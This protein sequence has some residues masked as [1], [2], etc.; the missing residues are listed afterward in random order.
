MKAYADTGFLVKLY[1][2][3]PGSPEA[4]KALAKVPR[5]VLLSEL[6][7]LELRNALNLNVFQKRITPAQASAAW[8]LFQSDLAA[9]LFQIPQLSSSAL[10]RQA[11]ELSDRHS[12]KLGTRSLDLLHLAAAQVLG[13]GQLLTF[14]ARQASAAKAE[15]LT[16]KPT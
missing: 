9:G 15:G 10:H 5:P 14:D 1:L 4:V 3:E 6:S 16:V 8:G 13:C 7:Q 2:L 11:R 12:P